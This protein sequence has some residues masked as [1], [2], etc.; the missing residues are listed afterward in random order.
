MK[1]LTDQF[2]SDRSEGKLNVKRTA[3]FTFEAEGKT[4]KFCI[5]F[6]PANLFVSITPVSTVQET[7]GWCH[8]LLQHVTWIY[9]PCSSLIPLPLRPPISWSVTDRSLVPSTTAMKQTK[10]NLK[11]CVQ[12]WCLCHWKLALPKAPLVENDHLLQSG[13]ALSC[14]QCDP[15]SLCTCFSPRHWGSRR[16]RVPQAPR[17]LAQGNTSYWNKV[18]WRKAKQSNSPSLWTLQSSVALHIILKRDTVL[19]PILNEMLG[20]ILFPTEN[21]C[22]PAGLDRKI[23]VGPAPWNAAWPYLTPHS[24]MQ[25]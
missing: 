10:K 7:S 12:L 11:N 21:G 23:A 17:S 16:L 3:I 14:P 1:F 18:L 2:P 9:K 19:S 20:T 13:V 24:S 4:D 5:P 22:V 25:Q 15:A 8:T 6:P